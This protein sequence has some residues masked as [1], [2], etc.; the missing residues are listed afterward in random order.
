MLAAQYDTACGLYDIHCKQGT[1]LCVTWD[2]QRPGGAVQGLH[3]LSAHLGVKRYYAG[4]LFTFVQWSTDTGEI[5]I[6]PALGRISLNVDAEAT[7]ELPSAGVYDLFLQET[8]AGSALKI[9]KG[10]FFLD[11]EVTR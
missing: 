3:G 8:P 6:D 7:S 10:M 11:K 4:S 2:I 9:V 5:V 1:D